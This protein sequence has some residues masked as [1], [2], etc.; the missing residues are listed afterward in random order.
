MNR[1][2]GMQI[3]TLINRKPHFIYGG[4]ASSVAIAKIYYEIDDFMRIEVVDC[5][6]YDDQ[7]TFS[8]L[9]GDMCIA[10]TVSSPGTTINQALTA[11]LDITR[12]YFN[13]RATNI[14]NTYNFL[15]RN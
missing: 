12:Q 3:A 10:T 15:H 7:Y 14:Q 2:L 9:L 8:M 1:E 4:R 13:N 5:E 11:L 6:V